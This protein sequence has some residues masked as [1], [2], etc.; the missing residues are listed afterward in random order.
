M[1]NYAHWF[2]CIGLLAAPYYCSAQKEEISVIPNQNHKSDEEPMNELDSFFDNPDAIRVA[3][4]VEIKEP[5]LFVFMMR[6]AL[7][8]LAQV[9]TF[10]VLKF[11]KFKSWFVQQALYLRLIGGNSN[12]Q[13]HESHQ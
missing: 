9:Y 2:L 7:S 8:P 5:S 12:D 10:T 1:K 3:D 13:K 6:R 4:D 11:R